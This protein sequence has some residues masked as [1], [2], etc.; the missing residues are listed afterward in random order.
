[1][2]FPYRYDPQ[3]CALV[4]VD[5]Q[6]DFCHPDGEHGRH[7]KDL[8]A[9]DAMVPR[10]KSLLQT[11]RK[12]SVQI[13]F[14]KTTH[15]ETTDSVPWLNRHADGPGQVLNQS[16]CRTGSWG[17][18]FHEVAP[19]PGEPVVVKHRYSAFAGT[20]LDI[21]L[22]TMS[23]KSVLFC[24]V[25]TDVCVD[26]SMRDALYLDYFASLIEDCCATSSQERQSAAV[27]ILS[28][29][30]GQAIKSSDLISIW[31]SA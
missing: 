11:A 14:V 29:Y 27:Q 9:V 17:S 12:A 23:I 25:A 20:N 22:R 18:E 15:D 16:V 19:V 30:F 21:I 24:G 10:L 6:K 3:H 31:Q 26:A 13:V 2:D 5:V 1:M 4:V 7:G 8:S 28:S